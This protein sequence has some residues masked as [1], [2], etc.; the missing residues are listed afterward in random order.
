MGL[1]LLRKTQSPCCIP[2][3][4][5]DRQALVQRRTPDENW[6]PES[7]HRPLPTR[8]AAARARGRSSRTMTR[9]HVCAALWGTRSSGRPQLAFAPVGIVHAQFWQRSSVNRYQRS[10]Y[11]KKN[12]RGSIS[13]V[14]LGRGCLIRLPLPVK[15]ARCVPGS[16]K[17]RLFSD[18]RTKL[19]SGMRVIVRSLDKHIQVSPP[20]VV[21]HMPVNYRLRLH[22]AR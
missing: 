7:H 17:S 18:L 21:L 10:W 2:N 1:G 14:P 6:G 20:H 4:Q 12:D 22:R 15:A 3:G 16:N 13:L 9:Q 11:K 8:I 19:Y 5:R